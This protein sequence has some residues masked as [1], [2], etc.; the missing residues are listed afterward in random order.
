VLLAPIAGHWV[1]NFE[2]TVDALQA[3]GAPKHEIQRLREQHA[4]N[5]RLSRLHAD[6]VVSGNQAVC[7]GVPSAE[8][9][10]FGMHNHDGKVCGK[11]WHH[12][13]RHDP[14]DMSKCYVRMAIV[15]NRLQLEVKMSEGSPDLNDPDLVSSPP[16]DLDSAAKC[17]AD[18]PAG[19][20]WTPWITYVFTRP[21]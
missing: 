20:Q 8:Y 21:R 3:A 5:P 18:K 1:F 14:G 2:K 7:S 15:E 16:V 10:F 12:E 17:D 6:M 4:Q 9:D 13:D 11:A 19:G